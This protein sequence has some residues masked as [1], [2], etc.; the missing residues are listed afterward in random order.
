VVDW[1]E[2]SK[3]SYKD[4]VDLVFK[5]VKKIYSSEVGL[6]KFVQGYLD[7]SMM[8]LR[9]IEK[10][11]GKKSLSLLA[12]IETKENL[13]KYYSDPEELEQEKKYREMALS[14]FM[15]DDEEKRKKILEDIDDFLS[16]LKN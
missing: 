2:I 3:V 15:E 6:K 1:H 16:K 4:E 14:F 13:E 9:D 10:F 5:I 11:Y 8:H 12:S 7:G